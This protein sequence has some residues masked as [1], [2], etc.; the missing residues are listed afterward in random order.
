M[1]FIQN[2]TLD[3]IALVYAITGASLLIPICFLFRLYLRFFDHVQLLYLFYISLASTSTIFS[4]YLEI[5]WAQLG[6]NLFTFCK[7]GD[8]ICTLGF[9]LSFTSCLV[10]VIL[11][12]F[13]IT[14]IVACSKP[15]ISFQP[16]YRY[17]KGVIKWTYIPMVYYS[18]N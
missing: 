14:R 10:G 6:Y 12:A 9:Q 3:L 5:S 17:I 8:L 7:T 2:D 18:F 13:L 11:L 15:R 16:V 4:T 1:G